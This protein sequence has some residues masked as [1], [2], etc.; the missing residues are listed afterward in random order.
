MFCTYTRHRYQVI[1][2]RTIGPLVLFLIVMC[3]TWSLASLLCDDI[4]VCFFILSNNAFESVA[5]FD[6]FL[7][8][9]V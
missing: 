8:Y 5:W 1:V 2:Y 7:I 9:Y 3:G 4:N 6:H